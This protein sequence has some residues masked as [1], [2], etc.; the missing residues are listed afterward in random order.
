MY[1][2]NHEHLCSR[3]VVWM[4]SVVRADTDFGTF[5]A[6]ILDVL[7]AVVG[8]ARVVAKIVIGD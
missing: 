1:A 8:E 6:R 5:L 3:L 2:R 4:R 7:G